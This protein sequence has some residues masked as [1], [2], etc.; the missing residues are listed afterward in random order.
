MAFV[1]V[2]ALAAVGIGYFLNTKAGKWVV[3]TIT[4]NLV[5]PLI[6]SIESLINSLQSK[7]QS[8]FSMFNSNPL[9]YELVPNPTFKSKDYQSLIELLLNK[10]SNALDIDTLLHT[11]PNY[12]AYPTPTLIGLKDSTNSSL[13][14]STPKEA[15]HTH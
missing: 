12:L 1:G 15:L 5:K 2:S 8:F 10:N 9:E 3:N 4:E 6:E 7:L 13:A 11:F 14:L